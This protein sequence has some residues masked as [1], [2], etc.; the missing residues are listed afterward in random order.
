VVLIAAGDRATRRR[1]QQ[2]LG[3]SDVRE[4]VDAHALELALGRGRTCV[5]LLD[6]S[7]RGLGGVA[8]V[9]AVRRANPRSRLILLTARPSTHE[10]V[11][12]LRAGARGYCRRT[13]DAAL[14][15]KAVAVVQK[16]EVWVGR[17]LVARIVDQLGGDGVERNGH[18]AADVSALTARERE[19]AALVAAGG[20][21]KEIAGRLGVSERTVKAHLTA[22][23]RKL[24]VTDRLRLALLMHSAG[25]VATES[26]R[27]TTRHPT[28]LHQ[29]P[30]DLAPLAA[31]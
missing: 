11:A 24:G 29:S 18:S 4:A 3:G 5:V 15:R 23:F 21:N 20:A 22:V 8:G 17:A 26:P 7:L 2:A 27:G 16:G 25:P 31:R 30:M 6:L 9:P 13:I 19:I 28:G 12:G 1:W 14:L 10:A